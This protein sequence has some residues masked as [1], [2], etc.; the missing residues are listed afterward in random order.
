M[1]NYGMQAFLFQV[2]AWDLHGRKVVRKP[3]G[4][5]AQR[6]GGERFVHELNCGGI[7][8]PLHNI[9]NFAYA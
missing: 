5:L 1:H 4:I 9:D 7:P 8:P 3:G 6:E 2:L